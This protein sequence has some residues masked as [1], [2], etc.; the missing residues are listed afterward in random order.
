MTEE[1]PRVE[2]RR[3][4]MRWAEAGT[5]L[6]L[7]VAVGIVGMTAAPAVLRATGIGRHEPQTPFAPLSSSDRGR[8]I[9]PLP[10]SSEESSEDD[11]IDDV[12]ESHARVGFA[13]RPLVL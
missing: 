6:L 1:A 9:I 7:A 4:A 11:A 5:T 2:K 12:P 3:R 10:R 13:R 8:G